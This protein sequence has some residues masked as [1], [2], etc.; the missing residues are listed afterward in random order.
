MI[1]FIVIGFNI[2]LFVNHLTELDWPIYAV[3]FSAVYFIFVLYLIWAPL[4]VPETKET[5]DVL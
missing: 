3:I 4:Q 2:Q 5:E 1:S